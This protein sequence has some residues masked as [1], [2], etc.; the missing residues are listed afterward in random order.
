MQEG[1]ETRLETNINAFL[2]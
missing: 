1:G 2:E